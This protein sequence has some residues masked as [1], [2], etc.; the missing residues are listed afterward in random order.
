MADN[1]RVR[2]TIV[3][4][5]K[6]WVQ[7]LLLLPHAI[8][9]GCLQAAMAWMRH[10]GTNRS[11]LDF[12]LAMFGL[13]ALVAALLATVAGFVIVFLRNDERRYWP[14]LA[15]HVIAIGLAAFAAGDWLSSHLA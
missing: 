1:D 6:H 3:R 7:L 11:D 10:V 9:F 8:S 13:A 2:T 5:M 15:V 12:N 4:D 14:W